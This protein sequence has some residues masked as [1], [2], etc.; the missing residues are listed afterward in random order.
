[1]NTSIKFL[2]LG[3]TEGKQTTN[4][5]CRNEYPITGINES[6]KQGVNILDISKDNKEKDAF[7]GW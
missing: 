1:M 5:Y 2:R 4:C 3:K 6:A 7:I